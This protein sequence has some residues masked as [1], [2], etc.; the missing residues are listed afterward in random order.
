MVAVPSEAMATWRHGLA[1]VRGRQ[2]LEGGWA[3]WAAKGTVGPLFFFP[4]FFEI[5]SSLLFLAASFLG[6][7]ERGLKEISKQFKFPKIAKT[8]L[9][10]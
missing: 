1:A 7:K 4:L 10:L 6:I 2:R 8:F 3:R 5:A 9:L